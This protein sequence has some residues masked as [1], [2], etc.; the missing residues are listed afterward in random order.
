MTNSY[1]YVDS[2][3]GFA[4]RLVNFVTLIWKYIHVAHTCP[5]PT[6]RGGAPLGGGG[7]GFPFQILRGRGSL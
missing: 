5:R 3:V 6:G 2:G 1:N 7:K 4:L